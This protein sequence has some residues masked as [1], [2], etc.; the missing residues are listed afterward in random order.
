MSPPT[1]LIISPVPVFPTDQGNRA[2]ILTLS[3]FL[4]DS[5]FDV[6]FLH[7]GHQ[8]GDIEAMRRYW[9]PERYHFV[10]SWKMDWKQGVKKP[11]P[12]KL[13]RYQYW[14]KRNLHSFVHGEKMERF[15]YSLDEWY[16]PSIDF[17]I[18]KLKN[19]YQYSM[20]IVNYIFYS[21]A[22]LKFDSGTLKI[23]DTLDVF[24]DRNKPFAGKSGLSGWFSV[25]GRDEISGLE[26]ADV[27]VAIQE[28]E[29]KY[30]RE[31]IKSEVITVGHLVR[32]EKTEVKVP[33]SNRILFVGSD[34]PVNRDAIRF[35]SDE[36]MPA[37]LAEIPSAK[38]VIAGRLGNV[39]NDA[40]FIE[41]SGFLED[42][43]EAY[44][45]CDIV[46][47]V[48]RFGTGLSIKTIEALG[49]G[50]PVIAT[51]AGAMGLNQLE[52]IPFLR[53]DS[54]EEIVKSILTLLKNDELRME[55]AEKSISFVKAYNEKATGPLLEVIARH[56]DQGRDS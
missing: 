38:L 17:A 51:E 5:G 35:L 53:A 36:I 11:F 8:I 32:C 42:I 48:R 15:N 18:D 26:R 52:N 46:L 25:S 3:T 45:N 28:E 49:F 50:K 41:K 4:R 30:F 2:R 37:V 24:A 34:N 47:N 40:A 22:F 10:R 55:L 20:V 14:I 16:S 33:V 7:V 31:I 56:L 1:I 23:L 54:S 27:A 12:E 29:E 21:R 39:V 43:K 6:H 44:D 19:S 13:K 9:G